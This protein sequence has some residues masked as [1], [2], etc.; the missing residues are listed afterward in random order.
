MF[1]LNSNI[2][3][4]DFSRK[5]LNLVLVLDISGSMDSNMEEY[6]YDGI[7]DNDDLEENSV[8][9][10]MKVAEESINILLDKLNPD[11]KVGVVLFDDNS[12]LAKP[13][14]LVGDTDIEAIKEH[15]LEIEAMGG[16][17]F[18]AGIELAREQFDESG[19]GDKSEYENRMIIITD[20]MPN[21]GETS[22][23]GLKKVLEENSKD[24]IYSSFIGVGVDFNTD[25][26]KNITDIEGANYYSVSSEEEFNAR[27]GE[28]FEYMVTPL[29][30][31]L[32]MDVEADGFEI[33]N[34]YGT[35]SKT[36][37]DGN[38][39]HINTL[40]PSKTNDDGEVKGGII[41][42]KLKKTSQDSNEFKINVSYTTRDGEKETASD[43]VE[44][45]DE[46]SYYDNSG[47]RKGI[48][49]ARYVNVLKN[50]IEYERKENKKYLITY[51]DGI[52]DFILP[53][54]YSSENERS[55]VELTVSKEYKDIFEKFSEYFKDEKDEIGDEN[56][57][58][59]I[60]ILE[61]LINM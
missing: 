37:E 4:E 57:S 59:E 56:L 24:G 27:M 28:E 21:I 60:D 22:S 39:M 44:F 26:I 19:I 51:E 7:P 58:K 38:I 49:L 2:K 35:D 30:F 43:T 61:K 34:I 3:E 13:I 10:K 42:L 18:E 5:K 53:N 11:D 14:N 20:A 29:V 40:F 32:N 6:Y 50:W 54:N 17:N 1:G 48:L 25:V 8:K 41:I 23:S 47:I 36:A 33:E 9:T 16:T 55:S 15:V 45:K 52:Q 12:Y 31:D 46:D